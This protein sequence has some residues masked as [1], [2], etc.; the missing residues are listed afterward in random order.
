MNLERLEI[1]G[2][3]SNLLDGI[4]VDN[5]KFKP[6]IS[7][8]VTHTYNA[9]KIIAEY[10]KPICSSQYKVSDTQEFPSLI[11][12]QPPS[13]DDEEYASYDVDPMFA[14][15][16]VGETIEYIIHQIYWRKTFHLYTV[17][18]FLTDYY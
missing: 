6:I 9:A 1:A 4:N 17:S 8:V 5:L 3:S 14:F 15:I 7:E 11:K 12:D 16:P 13:N 18:L 10:L 2:K